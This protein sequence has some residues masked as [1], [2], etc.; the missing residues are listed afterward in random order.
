VD[1][2]INTP[3]FRTH[4]LCACFCITDGICR[5]IDRGSSGCPDGT[6]PSGKS[7]GA[8]FAAMSLTMPYWTYD[9]VMHR[10]TLS[11]L[12]RSS[13]QALALYRFHYCRQRPGR[14]HHRLVLGKNFRR[15]LE[16]FS[17]ISIKELSHHFQVCQQPRFVNYWGR[18]ASC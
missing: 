11:A 18:I 17:L 10:S 7:I 15:E 14:V 3:R 1:Q 8:P 4:A 16:I 6:K 13:K 9:F 12:N 2:R 5:N